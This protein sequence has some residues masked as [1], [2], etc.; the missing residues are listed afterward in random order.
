MTSPRNVSRGKHDLKKYKYMHPNVHCS[1]VHNSQD[2]GAT[3]MPTNRRMNEEDVMR[4]RV[5]SGPTL[6]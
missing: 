5:Q 1:A 6:L 2:M 3:Q 4:V